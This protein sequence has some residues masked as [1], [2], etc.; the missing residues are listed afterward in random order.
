MKTCNFEIYFVDYVTGDLENRE[1][2]SFQTHLESCP[3]CPKR[4]DEFYVLHNKIKLRQRRKPD[5]ELLVKYHKSLSSEFTDSP[6]NV[7][8]TNLKFRS[9]FISSYYFS[10]IQSFIMMINVNN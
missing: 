5:S 2:I 7:K 4:L 10:S 1:K 3:T 9:F 6:Q 8:L